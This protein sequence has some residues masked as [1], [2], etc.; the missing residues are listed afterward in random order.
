[1]RSKTEETQ[2]RPRWRG[3]LDNEPKQTRIGVFVVLLVLSTAMTF[4]QLGFVGLGING[5]YTAFLYVLLCPVAAAALLFGPCSGG[6]MGFM[7][8]LV[9]YLHSRVQPLDMVEKYLVSLAGS[10]ILYTLTGL[11]LG[12]L[13]AWAFRKEQTK[14][15][16]AIKIALINLIVSALFTFAFD[17]DNNYLLD[18]IKSSQILLAIFGSGG[19]L[20]EILGDAA[21]A[22]L[23]CLLTLAGVRWYEDAR[24][25]ISVR[26]IVRLQLVIS[27]FLAFAC[28]TSI[29]F[30]AITAVETGRA[31]ESISGELDYI[32][33]Q[34]NLRLEYLKVFEEH[35]KIEELNPEAAAALYSM[36]SPEEILKGY[37][38][39]DGTLVMYE[40]GKRV[41]TTNP[42]F[43]MGGIQGYVTSGDM[44][45]II[46]DEYL[47]G[48]QSQSGTTTNPEYFPEYDEQAVEE[49]LSTG[50]LGGDFHNTNDEDRKAVEELSA[51]GEMREILYNTN[52]DDYQIGYMQARYI[53][54]GFTLAYAK[55]YSLVF[56][57]RQ[58]TMYWTSFITF[59]LLA[60][61]Y[62]LVNALLKRSV[63]EPVN[64]TNE[65]LFRITQGDLDAMVSEVD[66]NEF[67][68]L[69]AGINTCVFFLKEYA[70]ESERRI[71]RDL[72][73]ARAIQE[74]A[75]PR[76]F[77]AFPGIDEVSLFASMNAAKEVGGDFYDFFP[78]DEDT[79]GFLIADVSGKGIPGALFMMAAKTELSG[80]M[81]AGIP[82]AQ[83]IKRTNEYLCSHN[84][85]GMFVT[86][87]AATLKWRTGELT[88]VN[89]G[90]NFPLLRHGRGGDWEWIKKKCGLFLGTFDI[91]KYRQETIQ[92]EP[93]DQLLLYTDGVN[94]A[95][96]VDEEEYGNDRLEAFLNAN[97]DLR[98][99]AMVEAL[100]A[101]V[102]AW[103][104]GAEQSDDITIL[105]LEYGVAPELHYSRTYAATL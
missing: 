71:E 16:L 49:L 52:E 74:G 65:V 15:R 88:Y 19:S 20:I 76:N 64:R 9:L 105:T 10:I 96:N 21:L 1:M 48:M 17:F 47:E 31:K 75:L 5:N 99:R 6:A 100:R 82:L 34:F 79:V 103:A 4:L 11:L 91:A 25:H 28:I 37:D 101:D 60:T 36:I 38:L 61:V 97:A 78:I 77:P 104:E 58:T 33:T 22:T 7:V 27:L 84:E 87:W 66:S 13:Y 62:I 39:T 23:T 59:V 85:A 86:V 45:M 68:S 89:A 12:V 51:T 102:A 95:F 55:P 67:A 94:E 53:G 72:A 63:V 14:A 40:G 50:E 73:T 29:S 44:T 35:Q 98:P 83:A 92:L 42:A 90:H 32:E 43:D 30:V 93:G 26:T 41:Y 56:Q 69:S 54:E 46:T 2:R 70:A 24:N 3:L 80:N 8:G 18:T 57:N 81:Q